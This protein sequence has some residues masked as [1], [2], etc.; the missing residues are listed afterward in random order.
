MS[1]T[2]TPPGPPPFDKAYFVR[3]Y[4][5]AGLARFGVHW[6]PVRWYAEMAAR[7]LRR[8]GG[9]RLLEIG[10]GQG[11]MLARLED[12]YE[13]WGVDISD[14]AIEQARGFAPRSRL[15][16]ADFAAGLPEPFA[17]VSFDLVVAKYV[18]EHLADPQRALRDIFALL[19]PGGT[20]LYAVPNTGSL[21]ARLKGE[22]W[23]AH[24]HTD[25]TH[26][27]LLSR[28]QWLQLTEAAGLVV[29]RE[30]AD[31]WWDVPYVAWLPRALQLPLFIGP[32]ALAC[33]SGRAVLPARW[34]E[35]L[36]VFAQRPEMGKWGQTAI[37]DLDA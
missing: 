1:A 6:W 23:Y 30:S 29:E 22:R 19:R 26:C 9:S 12:R 32:T 24:P 10:C 28:Q 31:G 34:G 15:F 25:P 21:G 37:S 7:C 36:L 2:G 8:N 17:G 18:L 3:T 4:G 14:F 33:L 5:E 11:F 20:L 16:A 27:S 35:N 13:T